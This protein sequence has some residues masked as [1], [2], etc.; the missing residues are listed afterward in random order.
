M[1]SWEN[2]PV[3]IANLINPAFCGFL[4]YEFIKGHEEK[5]D[6]EVGTPYELFFLM[7]P[8]I[9]HKPTKLVLPRSVST[10]MHVWL[11]E[12]PEVRVGFALRAK[13]LV[14]FTKEAIHFLMK[15]EIITVNENGNFKISGKI[16]PSV[17]NS[18]ENDS[19]MYLS[20]Y[21]NKAKM[22]GRWFAVTGTS[23]T[24]YT[25]WGVSP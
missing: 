13:E 11:Q 12:K 18:L 2:R 17:I 7:L 3:E 4:I 9:L 10:Y 8:I 16:K 23:S 19:K 14:P 24:I 22:L 20:D 15:R 6:S 5:V 25:M 1:N 21:Q